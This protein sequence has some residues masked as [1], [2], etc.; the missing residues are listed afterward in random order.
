[1]L[2]YLKCI[3]DFGPIS[4]RFVLSS[5]GRLIQVYD[6]S[7][8]VVPGPFIHQVNSDQSFYGCLNSDLK[9]DDL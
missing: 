3:G 5:L 2:K 7:F 1:M 6:I 9:F 8:L 4:F